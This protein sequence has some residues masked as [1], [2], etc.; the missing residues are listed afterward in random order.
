MKFDQKLK[1]EKESNAKFA[2]EQLLL[3]GGWV[4]SAERR[5]IIRLMPKGEVN[6]R[7]LEKEHAQSMKEA[8]AFEL[9]LVLLNLFCKLNAFCADDVVFVF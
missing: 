5:E 9:D 1:P 8:Q 6:R 2:A 7:R 3:K 4:G